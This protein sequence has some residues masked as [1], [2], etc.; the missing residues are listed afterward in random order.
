MNHC[1]PK[2]EWNQEPQEN[3]NKQ[4]NGV[5]GNIN[6]LLK[7]N[8]A[9]KNQEHSQQMMENVNKNEINNSYFDYSMLVP[10]LGFRF[11]DNLSLESDYNYRVS[12]FFQNSLCPENNP[13]ENIKDNVK[14]KSIPTTEKGKTNNKPIFFVNLTRKR[15]RKT[16][17]RKKRKFHL[18][19]SIDNILCKIQVHFLNFFIS[20]IN[21]VIKNQYQNKKLVFKKFNYSVKNRI[22]KEHM[23]FLKNSTINDVIIKLDIS[24]KYTKCDKDINKIILAKLEKNQFFKDFFQMKYL[25]LFKYYYNNKQPLKELFIFGQ[26]IIL[27]QQTK[28]FYD[29]IERNKYIS[30][31]IIKVVEKNYINNI[32]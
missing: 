23:N 3:L 22:N 32:D 4:T 29:L 30:N 24:Y 21:D 6:Q 12:S 14:M 8:Q 26:K 25:D 13:S 20:F 9:P 31:I 7:E 1:Y 16:N 19:S 28:S 11:G 5:F 17:D 18:A 10:E 27:S 15:G 2:I